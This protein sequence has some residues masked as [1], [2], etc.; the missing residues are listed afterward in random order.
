MFIADRL[1][2]VPLGMTVRTSL[3][4]RG[5]VLRLVTPIVANGLNSSPRAG[6][7]AI[8]SDART[9]ASVAKLM[10]KGALQWILLGSWVCY[11]SSSR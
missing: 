6:A 10:K 4:V 2:V 5:A 8:I 1:S 11:A 9:S 3:S 7:S